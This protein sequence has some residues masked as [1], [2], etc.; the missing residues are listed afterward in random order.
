MQLIYSLIAYT[1]LTLH[2]FSYSSENALHY[3]QAYSFYTTHFQLLHMLLFINKIP[4][5]FY[6][7]SLLSD[8]SLKIIL[9]YPRPKEQHKLG[10]KN[11]FITTI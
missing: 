3:L 2:Y 7:V 11:Q 8:W 4:L 1:L 6:L 5:T 9:L 10:R